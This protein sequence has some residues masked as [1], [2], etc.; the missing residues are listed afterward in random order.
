LV[1]PKKFLTFANVMIQD[2]EINK[3]R[4]ERLRLTCNLIDND[5]KIHHFQDGYEYVEIGGIKWATCNVGAEKETDSGLYF[6][7]GDVQG[8]TADQVGK[9]DG[10]KFFD[11]KDYKYCNDGIM[12][13]YNST[14]GKTVLEPSDD[15]ARFHMGSSWRMPTEKDFEALLASTTNKWVFNYKGSGVNGRLFTS[16]VDSFKTLFF[17]ACGGCVSGSVDYVRSYGFYWSNS[18]PS[19]RV[20]YGHNLYFDGGNCFVGSSSWVYGF[21]VRGVCN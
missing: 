18:L 12:T 1:I 19:S 15:A 2:F 4:V 13:K 16:K 7:W 20:V 10:E 21:S 11:W 5:G 3:K 17:P 9:G 6:Q 8:Y 14:D